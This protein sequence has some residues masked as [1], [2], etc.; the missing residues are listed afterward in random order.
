MGK[1]GFRTGLCLEPVVLGM[2]LSE[3]CVAGI[4]AKWDIWCWTWAIGKRAR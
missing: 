3:V 2:K 4:R 1:L